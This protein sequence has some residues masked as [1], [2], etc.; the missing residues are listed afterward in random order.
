MTSIKKLDLPELEK[1]RQAGKQIILICG[2]FDVLHPGHFRFI[3]HAAEQGDVLVVGLID[4]NQDPAILNDNEDRWH[5]LACLN[6]V[7]YIMLTSKDMGNII[8]TVRPHIVVKGKEWETADNP[9]KEILESLG[10][11]LSFSSGERFTSSHSYF[12]NTGGFGNW[13]STESIE[14][15]LR[16]HN[17]TLK[18]AQVLIDRFSRVRVAVFGDLIIDEY[19]ECQ[20]VG[21]SREDPTIVVTPSSTKQFLGGA[22]IVAAHGCGLGATVDFYSVMGCDDKAVFGLS[23]LKTYGAKPMLIQDDSRPTTCKRRYRALNKSLLRVNDFSEQNISLEL[24]DKVIA[25]FAARLKN[26]DV[27]IFSDFNYGFLPEGLVKKIIGLCR[28]A[29]IPTVADSQSSSHVGDLG[30]FQDVL[31]ITPTEYEARLTI[32][33]TQDGLIVISEM[34]GKKLGAKYVFITLGSEGI[35]IRSNNGK[36]WETDDFSALNLQPVDAAGAGDAMLMA[37]ALTLAVGEDI[38]LAAFI[39]SVASACQVGRVGNLPLKK[40]EM[41]SAL[42]RLLREPTYYP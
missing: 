40:D 11:K 5:A 29:G 4:D 10:G 35:L 1:A 7:T 38:W 34:L 6:M 41:E 19:V 13:Q 15:Y 16:R 21:M 17:I 31:M 3:R 2:Y 24:Q 25:D 37:S 9:E 30:K 27:V 18:R 33:N 12:S 28:D 36:N 42:K 39:G 26:Y 14:P 8:R 22:A 20:P 32:N 23:T